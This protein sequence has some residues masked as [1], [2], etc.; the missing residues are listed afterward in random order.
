MRRRSGFS[1]VEAFVAMALV[2]L[3]LLMLLTV[4]LMALRHAT[5]TRDHALALVL[6]ENLRER[7]EDHPFGLERPAHWGSESDPREQEYVVVVEGRQVVTRFSWSIDAAPAEKG[8][9][10]SFFGKDD[11]IYDVLAIRVSWTDGTGPASEG[12]SHSL[13]RYATVWQQGVPAAAGGGS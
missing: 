8:G 2:A 3:G 7:I 1:L 11:E 5:E 6:A 10:G 9:N 13:V 12:Q 4:F